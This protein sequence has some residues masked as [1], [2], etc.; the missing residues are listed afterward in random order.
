MNLPLLNLLPLKCLF[1]LMNLQLLNL[2]KRKMRMLL[3]LLL[4]N[5]P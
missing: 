5:P 3:S 2:P 1:P 4:L